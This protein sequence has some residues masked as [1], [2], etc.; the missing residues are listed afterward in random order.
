MKHKNKPVPKKTT[1]EEYIHN[2]IFWI[3]EYGKGMT[4]E[5]RC[6]EAIDS[7]KKY[8]EEIIKENKSVCL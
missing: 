2:C 1:R 6:I 7:L 5:K 3:N 4:D 8:C